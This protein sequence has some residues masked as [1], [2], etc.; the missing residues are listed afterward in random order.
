VQFA[1]FKVSEQGGKDCA[2]FF[3]GY[4]YQWAE[5]ECEHPT[6]GFPTICENNV[7]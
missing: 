2:L 3:D 1:D 6:Y 7:L 5:F 4:G